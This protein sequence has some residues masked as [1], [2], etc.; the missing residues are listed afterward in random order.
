[1]AFPRKRGLASTVRVGTCGCGSRGAGPLPWA[2]AC[3]VWCGSGIVLTCPK[4]ERPRE[5]LC[6]SPT[7]LVWTPCHGH[8]AAPSFLSP[9]QSL[10]TSFVP[11]RLTALLSVGVSVVLGPLRSLWAILRCLTRTT[12]RRDRRHSL[13]KSLPLPP[14]SFLLL[15]HLVQQNIV[16]QS[17]CSP[18]NTLIG[19]LSESI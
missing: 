17:I 10:E 6:H 12:G 14:I 15:F 4:W 3:V 13:S 7:S 11:L 9:A 2:S 18:K 19:G 8:S 5:E 16:T 1:M